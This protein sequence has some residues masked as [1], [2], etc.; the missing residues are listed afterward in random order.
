MIQTTSFLFLFSFR[1]KTKKEKMIIFIYSFAA[2]EE[3]KKN[4]NDLRTVIFKLHTRKEEYF[5]LF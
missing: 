5:I 2:G 3:D 4:H 1:I